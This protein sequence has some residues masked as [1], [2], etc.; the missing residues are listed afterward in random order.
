MTLEDLRLCAYWHIPVIWVSDGIEYVCPQIVQIAERFGTEEDVRYRRH[1]AYWVEVALL[2]QNGNSW[3]VVGPDD[4]KPAD[5]VA[6][7][8][9]KNEYYRRKEAAKG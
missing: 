5:A 3:I 7:E 9:R 2:D 6:F 8:A 4:V 1:P